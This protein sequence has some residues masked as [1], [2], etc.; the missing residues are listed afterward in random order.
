MRFLFLFFDGIGL[1]TDDPSINPFAR[2]NM[3]NLRDLLGGHSLVSKTSPYKGK[4]ATL[5]P[6]D[7][8]LGVEGLPQ[9]ATGQATL[10]SGK[11]VPAALG[12]HYGP[13]PNPDV[14]KFLRDGNLFSAL[15]KGG[16]RSALLNAYPPRYFEDI[17]RGRRL[18]S[19]IPLAVSSAG[20]PL[21]TE[22]DLVIGQALSADFTGQGWRDHLGITTTPLLEPY[23]AGERLVE[24]SAAYDFSF[25]DYWVSDFIGHRQSMMDA[26][27][28]LETFDQVLGGLLNAWDDNAGLVLLASDHGN[29]EDLSTRRHTY[30]PVPA[31][32]IG[33]ANFREAY[34]AGLHDLT[35]VAPAIKRFLAI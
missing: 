28:I 20:I 4:R 22:S 6:L 13:K 19:A 27:S 23:F 21:K 29:L 17:R 8:C 34:T 9:S 24:L 10:L 2:A 18:Y 16:R 31:L 5:L 12:H 11:N 33:S 14:G 32:L 26:C 3:P 15:Q 25:Y 35:D 30:N 7:A 1:G